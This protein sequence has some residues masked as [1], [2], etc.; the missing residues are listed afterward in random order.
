MYSSVLS[1]LICYSIFI[2]FSIHDVVATT[3]PTSPRSSSSLMIKEVCS[4][5]NLCIQILE[6]E[7]C[8][9]SVTNLFN[10]SIEIMNTGISNATN[11]RRYIEKLLRK[12]RDV[13]GAVHECKLSYDSVLGSLNSALSEVR[14]IKEC[15]TATYDLKN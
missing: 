13:K 12:C 2:S 4:C 8:I 14:E 11:T 6:F 10:L 5:S 3:S 1:V 7:H 15:E 9:V